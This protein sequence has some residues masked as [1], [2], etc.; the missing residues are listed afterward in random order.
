MI[1]DTYVIKKF[2][3]WIRAIPAYFWF[4]VPILYIVMPIIMF[5]AMYNLEYKEWNF[6]EDAIWIAL[7]WIMLIIYGIILLREVNKLKKVRNYKFNWWWMVKKAKV[8]SINKTRANKG[9]RWNYVDVYYIEAED[10]GMVY[11]SNWNTKWKL[12]WTS[13]DKLKLLYWMYWFTF[14]ENHDQKDDV[15]RK[16]DQSIS[17]KEYEVEN[18]SFI[19]K[20]K[21]WKELSKLKE[22]RE[23]VSYWY[24]AP[25]REIDD[26]KVTV[27]DMVDVYFNPDKP[28][29]Y[30][31][32][33]D[34]LFWD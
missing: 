24:V 8:I 28:E 16:I 17:E 33:I 1:K 25:Y 23:I 11:Y 15:L 34:F 27:W 5:I 30:R 4:L 3:N 10:S 2:G 7:F 14:N 31:V 18:A 9:G 20:I 19:S 6:D 12:L 13:L 22:D 26:K 29:K 21:R 32:D